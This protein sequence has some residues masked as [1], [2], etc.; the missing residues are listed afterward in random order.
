MQIHK[1]NQMSDMRLI[2]TPLPDS[3][4]GCIQGE[5]GD[6]FGMARAALVV[7]FPKRALALICYAV[8][9]DADLGHKWSI[10]LGDGEDAVLLREDQGCCEFSG[11]GM[12]LFTNNTRG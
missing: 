8:E 1:I 3:F 10:L 12:S 6:G 11:A 5:D 2:L 9:D 7:P 4:D